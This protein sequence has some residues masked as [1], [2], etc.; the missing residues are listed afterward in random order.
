LLITTPRDIC[1][2]G[3]SAKQHFSPL[4]QINAQDDSRLGL[5]WFMDLPP[6]NTVSAP[7]ES[8]GT[9][10][11]VAG[12]GIVHAVEVKSGTQLWVYDAKAPEQAGPKIRAAWGS[13]GI[14]WWHDKIHLGT[15]DGRLIAIDSRTGSPVWTVM[16][17]TRDDA[18]YITGAPRAF[19]G[20]IIIGFGGADGRL[21]IQCFVLHAHLPARS[22]ALAG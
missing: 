9:L 11:F 13:R 18:T 10:Y 3:G 17:T 22:N 19:D 1:W 5:A 8:A 20:K 4:T 21:L 14:A 16:T 6:G 2:K 12:W 7:L 15:A